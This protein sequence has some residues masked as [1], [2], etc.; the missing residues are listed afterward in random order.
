LSQ[1]SQAEIEPSFADFLEAHGDE[2]PLDR[3]MGWMSY[4][5]FPHSVDPAEQLVWLDEIAAGV[6][7]P[8]D[9][10]RFESLARINYHLFTE[11]GFAGDQEQYDH[12]ENSCLGPVLTRR[13]GLPIVMSAIYMEVARRCGVR[14]HGIGFPGH[15]FVSPVG[16]GPRFFLDAF[17]QGRVLSEEELLSRLDLLANRALPRREAMP[18]LAPASH[19]AMLLRMNIN[20]KRSYM[21]R[22]DWAGAIRT[23]ERILMICPERLDEIRDRGLVLAEFGRVDEGVEALEYYLVACPNA[24]DATELRDRLSAL[25][26]L[27]LHNSNG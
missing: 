12:P 6:C 2:V 20:L 4:E 24:P 14:I 23:I 26:G 10:D 21:A 9:C 8:P 17:H 18:F 19:R 11:L 27:A 5:E 25:R 7:M 15:F 3:A 16:E 1:V 13:R 22:E